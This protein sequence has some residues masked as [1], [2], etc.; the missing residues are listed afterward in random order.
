MSKALI[1]NAKQ[2]DAKKHT[3]NC[4]CFYIKK[5]CHVLTC[6]SCST[7]LYCCDIVLICNS[8]ASAFSN[9]SLL[10]NCSLSFCGKI[11]NRLNLH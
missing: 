2:L 7:V 1:Y 11:I 9:T 5:H 4:L 8:D 3:L 6:F 10:S